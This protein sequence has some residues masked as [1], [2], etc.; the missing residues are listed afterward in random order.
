M[1]TRAVH[2]EDGRRRTVPLV[3][4]EEAARG[5]CTVGELTFGDADGVA[6]PVPAGELGA[7]AV[8]D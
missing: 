5:R 4:G 2:G 3:P 8:L 6:V 7:G 1:R